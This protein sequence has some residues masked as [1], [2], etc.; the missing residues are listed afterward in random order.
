MII[1]A[2]AAGLTAAAML[3]LDGASVTVLE[4]HNAVG[5]CASSFVRNGV[6]FDVGATLAAGFGP[7][8]VHQRCFDALGVQIK[9]ER[10]DPAMVVHLPGAKVTRFGDARWR[11]ERLRVFGDDAEAFWSEQEYIADRAWDFAARFPMLPVDQPGIVSFLS[12]LRP[13]HVPLIRYLGRSVVS[14]MPR[15]HARLRRFIDA[16]LLITAQATAADADLLYGATALDLA[17]EG[18]YHLPQGIAQISTQLARGV[19]KHGGKI[20]YRTRA[21]HISTDDSGTV[22]GVETD[23]GFFPASSIISSLPV[24]DTLDLLDADLAATMTAKVDQMPARF[25]AFMAYVAMRPDV[26]PPD[27]VL[28]HQVVTTDDGPLGEGRSVFCS[29]SLPGERAPAGMR[30]ITISTHTD[31][32]HWELADF[33]GQIAEEKARLGSRLLDVLESIFPGARDGIAAVEYA[34]P[35][36]F[37]RYTGRSRGLVGGLPQKPW[38]ANIGAISHVSGVPGLALCGDTTF[39]GQSTVGAALSG[40]AAA[41]STPA[42]QRSATRIFS[43]ASKPT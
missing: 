32:A 29:L 33:D 37:A 35:L 2:G 22:T 31:V 11:A 26:I 4:Q 38:L 24:R 36:T 3:V 34:T 1:G 13:R 9:A 17:R 16:Q 14:I 30:A 7:R 42:S 8:G 28:H 18:V 41:R 15:D 25:G 19:R 23:V 21:L 43:E 5:G 40:I 6:K 20:A 39:P 27:A 10:V 12:A